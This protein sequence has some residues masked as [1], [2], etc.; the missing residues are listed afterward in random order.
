MRSTNVD[1]AETPPEIYPKSVPC[2]VTFSL[3]ADALNV[4]VPVTAF[5]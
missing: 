3:T 2:G 1:A 5:A 4:A